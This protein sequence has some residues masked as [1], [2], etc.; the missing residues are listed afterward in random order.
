MPNRAPAK[1]ATSPNPMSSDSWISPCG[2]MKI[3]QNSNTSPPMDSTA[4]VMS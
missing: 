3:P 2:A 1:V 4:A